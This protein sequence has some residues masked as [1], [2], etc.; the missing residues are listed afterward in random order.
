MPEPKAVSPDSS[1]YCYRATVLEVV[2]GDTAWMD[3]DLGFS[4]RQ[5]MSLRFYGINAPE[6]HGTPDAKPG[7]AAKEFL[8]S[9]IG[10]K[11]VTIRTQKD[12][13]DKFG[14]LLAEVFVT[15]NLVSVNQQMI[16]KGHAVA[17]FGG[18]R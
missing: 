3:V 2:D 9:L 6:L 17:Y 14:R 15:G 5:K 11:K 12:K 8:N 18:K 4:I 16:E 10:G 13:D 7:I 1:L